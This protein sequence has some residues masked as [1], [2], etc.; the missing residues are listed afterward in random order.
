MTGDEN[1]D[2]TLSVK[3]CTQRKCHPNPA[4]LLLRTVTEESKNRHSWV[5]LARCPLTWP[6]RLVIWSD[7]LI[8]ISIPYHI[9]GGGGGRGCHR[10][11]GG[12]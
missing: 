10:K 5:S 12:G 9:P 6:G 7:L 4:G 1:G 3:T 11:G 2:D 8:T